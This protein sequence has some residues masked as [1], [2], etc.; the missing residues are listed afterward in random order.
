[1]DRKGHVTDNAT[2]LGLGGCRPDTVDPGDAEKRLVDIRASK[3][4]P[5]SGDRVITFEVDHD[6]VFDIER[7]VPGHSN[8]LTI[9]A[10]DSEGQLL[11][12]ETWYSDGGDF[13]V[14]SGEQSVA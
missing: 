3:R 8:S 5:S 11:L 13:I 1:M 14:R 4:L 9:A 10:F 2:L 6:I 12:E 7:M